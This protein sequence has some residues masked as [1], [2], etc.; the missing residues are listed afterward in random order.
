MHTMSSAAH[1]LQVSGLDAGYVPGRPVVRGAS[2]QLG[3]GEAVAILGPNGSGKSTL[4]RAMAGLLPHTSGSIR[5]QLP[6][7]AAPRAAHELLRCGISFV[8][9]GGLVLPELLV[10]EHFTL[11]LRHRPKAEQAAARHQALAAFPALAPLMQRRGGMLSGGERQQLSAALLLAQGTR[12]W[13]MD[14][15]TAGLSPALVQDTLHFLQRMHSQHG[16]TLL[17]VEHD[18]DVA[19]QL[20]GRV[21]VMREGEIIKT[22]D[23]TD[24]AQLRPSL[25]TIYD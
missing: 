12:V 4:L 17:V 8:P 22:F 10:A 14:E 18:L 15:P 2:L 19:F 25:E 9:Q 5:W 1:I 3:T 6:G 21:L 24:H 16:I 13:L 23:N 7:G 11:A 20:A